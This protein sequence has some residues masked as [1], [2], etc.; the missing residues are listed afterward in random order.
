MQKKSCH[1][2][3]SQ[4]VTYG[5]VM[6]RMDES[7][8]RCH[9][10]MRHV[11]YGWDMSHINES[12]QRCHIW[13]SS[14]MLKPKMFKPKMQSSNTKKIMSHEQVISH[15]KKSYHIWISHVT[16]ESVM[17]VTR[18][19]E[20]CHVSDLSRLSHVWISHVTY[21]LAM[22]YGWVMSLCESVL[23]HSA[24]HCNTPRVSLA[25]LCNTLQHT[26]IHCNTLRHTATHRESVLQHSATRC[27][28]LR[29]TATHCNALQHTASQVTSLIW[30]GTMGWLHLV[31]LIKL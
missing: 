28:T 11:T 19:H 29:Y 20:S 22:S 1:L 10:W 8:H 14:I 6:S 4:F 5:E 3:R 12:C 7:W 21:G 27:N 24:T 15:V 23:Q 18:M 13:M 9:I 2:S 30:A 16:Y 31:G 26:T 17:H 25:T